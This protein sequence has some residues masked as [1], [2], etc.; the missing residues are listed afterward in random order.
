M[1]S[2]NFLTLI[3]ILAIVIFILIWL[4]KKFKTLSLPAVFFVSGAVKSGKSLLS[5]HLAIKEYKRNLRNYWIKYW[6]VKF[7]LPFKFESTYKLYDRYKEYSKKDLSEMTNEELDQF[8]KDF[9]KLSNDVKEYLPPMLYSNI[10]LAYVRFNKLTI[11]I[12]LNNVR[13]PRKSVVLIDEVSLFADSM[14]FKDVDLNNKLTRFV[15]LF[16]H[17]THGGKLIIDSQSLKDN[18]FSFKR[19][20]DRYLYIYDRVKFPFFSVLSV[21]EMMSMEDGQVTNVITEDLELSLRKVLIFNR[22]Y[23]KYDCYCYSVYSDYLPVQ[24]CYSTKV[25]NK[26][27]DLKCYNIVSLNK[28]VEDMN[29]SIKGKYP[30]TSEDSDNENIKE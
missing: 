11:D 25:L 22:T 5:V 23:D 20:M 13:M 16:G 15:K 17:S 26:K 19:C 10:P 3:I 1:K 21:R 12:I 14:L 28:F 7:I 27:D 18:H 6:L 30:V 29:E 9:E 4:R 24:V 8:K 2:S